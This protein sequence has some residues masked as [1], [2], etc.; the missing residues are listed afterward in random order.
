M[1]GYETR[2]LCYK[3]KSDYE[4]AGYK[5]HK[6]VTNLIKDKCEICGKAGYEYYIRNGE[7]MCNHSNTKKINNVRVCLK[8][9]LTITDDGKVLFDRKLPNYKSKKKRR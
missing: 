6:V 3:C 7:N 5:L 9:G 4:S 1:K 2:I 8:C